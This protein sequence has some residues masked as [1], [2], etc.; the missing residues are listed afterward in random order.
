M[1]ERHRRALALSAFG[2]I[3]VASLVGVGIMSRDLPSLQASTPPTPR[4]QAAPS[5]TSGSHG[6]GY[7]RAQFGAPWADVDG[8][9]C[10]TNL[11]VLARWL[12]DVVLAPDGCTVLSG[13]LVDPYTEQTVRYMRGARPQP[14]QMDH[15]VPL[16]VAWHGG[17]DVAQPATRLAFA[18]DTSNLLPT[19]L[20]SSKGDDGP[21]RL[22]ERRKAGRDRWQPT[23]AG[24]CRYAQ[25]YVLAD[26]EWRLRTS[27]ADEAALAE[28]L[29]ACP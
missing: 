9:G 5:S 14:V 19:T 7:S 10:P 11:D 16:H 28:M 2:A 22:L 18:N 26:A 8:N 12:T 3:A 17:L 24:E 23:P 29:R 27:D 15:V 25:A 20:N 21:A 13:V 6:D 1:R 4:A